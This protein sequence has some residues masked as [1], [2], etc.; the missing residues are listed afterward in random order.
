[1]DESPSK[2]YFAKLFKQIELLDNG[3]PSYNFQDK[4]KIGLQELD[5]FILT[6]SPSSPLIYFFLKCLNQIYY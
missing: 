1:M 5:D 2:W 6:F 3:P 4:F